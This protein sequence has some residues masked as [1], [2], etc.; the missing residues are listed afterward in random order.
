MSIH[1]VSAQSTCGWI[2]T[3]STTPTTASI[4]QLFVLNM[5]EPATCDGTI[6]NYQYCYYPLMN[7]ISS[8]K[9]I[10]L[11]FEFA[12]YRSIN[13]SYRKMSD[14]IFVAQTE[15]TVKQICVTGYFSD[16]ISV[17]KGDVLGACV[18]I[19]ADNASTQVSPIGNNSN[20]NMYLLT[21]GIDLCS[22]SIPPS[23]PRQS[24]TETRGLVLHLSATVLSRTNSG[25][26]AEEIVA[27]VVPLAAIAIIAVVIIV[28]YWSCK[29]RHSI[30][31]FA[32][33]EPLLP[34]NSGYGEYV[35]SYVYILVVLIAS[36]F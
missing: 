30:S 24:L 22:G 11:S 10:S 6:S 28:I 35:I 36:A 33:T 32:S 2:G 12:V 16:P 5:L 13:D 4:Q 17:D 23:I 29:R 19:S 27:I 3:N 15:V 20:S 9:E 21:A 18:N 26:I 25:L 7:E 34:Q 31:P 8:N 14:S 1:C